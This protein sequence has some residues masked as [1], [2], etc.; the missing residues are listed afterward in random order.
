M[1]NKNNSAV[2]VILVA[3]LA[4]IAVIGWAIVLK[5]IGA[6]N[7]SKSRVD[8][9][10]TTVQVGTDNTQE[11]DEEEKSSEA[12]SE[13]NSEDSKSSE[14]EPESDTDYS[15]IIGGWESEAYYEFR[16]D[17]TYGW[18]KSS[19]D[20]S[21]NYY[22]GTITVLRGY[23]ACDHLDITLDRVLTVFNNS[24]GEVGIDDIY[25]ITC[26]PTYLVSGGVDKSD[27]LNGVSYDLLFVVVGDKYAQGLNVGNG[28][29]Y[30]FTKIK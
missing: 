15:D 22:S 1:K 21:D 7:Q 30:Y 20:L 27:T 3:A 14:D 24:N 16:E 10:T 8:E 29:S 28:D 6:N 18:Y 9:D 5:M 23:E 4:V 12:T 2:V 26:T 25:C 17:G 19:E 11:N 13:E